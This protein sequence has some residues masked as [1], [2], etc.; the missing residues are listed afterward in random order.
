M[1]QGK[2][3]ERAGLYKLRLG[4]ASPKRLMRFAP[5]ERIETAVGVTV[6]SCTPKHP[7]QRFRVGDRS[8]WK[9]RQYR[10]TSV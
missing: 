2:W 5:T 4:L 8:H 1:G 9:E 10:Q 6:Q 3:P 7:S